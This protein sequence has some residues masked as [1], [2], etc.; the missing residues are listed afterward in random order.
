MAALKRFEF[1]QNGSS[2]V[3]GNPAI[4]SFLVNLGHDKNGKEW[5]SQVSPTGQVNHLLWNVD[6]DT[7]D[8][9]WVKTDPDWYVD[10][11]DE[12]EQYSSP[13]LRPEV[14]YCKFNKWGEMHRTRY[15]RKTVE[16]HN[17][18]RAINEFVS[19][20]GIE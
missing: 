8:E 9:Y 13:F 4:P 18:L 7:S 16:Y 6:F 19:M 3:G 15:H 5:L 10:D 2:A 1:K 20:Y 12:G 17:I 11:D 14:V